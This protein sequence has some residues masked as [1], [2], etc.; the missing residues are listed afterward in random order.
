MPREDYHW[1]VRGQF[2]ESLNHLVAPYAWHPVVGDDDA[3]RG[4][5]DAR[6]E[7]LQSGGTAL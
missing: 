5:I 4:V 6:K 1:Q 3:E 7:A 2:P